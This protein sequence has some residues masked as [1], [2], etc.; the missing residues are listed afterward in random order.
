VTRLV[1]R[2]PSPAMVVALIALFIALGGGAYAASRL[3][4]H[5]VGT[6]QLKRGAVT[7][8]ILHKNAVTSAKVKDHSLLARDFKPGQLP[9][10]AKGDTG[11]QGPPG[12]TA[13]AYAE[14]ASSTPLSGTPVTVASLGQA[15]SAQSPST[16][17]ISVGYPARLI[18]NGAVDITANSGGDVFCFLEYAPAGGTF[19]AMSAHAQELDSTPTASTSGAVGSFALPVLGSADVGPGSYDVRVRCGK[20]GTVAS[21]TEAQVTVIATAR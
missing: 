1:R 18:A 20:T 17:A 14:S 11:A 2:R 5:S 15:Q 3:P 16:G 8:G 13:S 12:P 7:G 4:R 6:R 21:S 9:A 10:G 19:T